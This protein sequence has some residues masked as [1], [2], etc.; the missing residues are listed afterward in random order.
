MAKTA[1]QL[2]TFNKYLNKQP[3]GKGRPSLV[4]SVE[5][6]QLV[7]MLSKYMCTDEEMA[8][9]LGTTVETLHNKNNRETFLDCKK[10]GQA[11]GKV[12]LRRNQMKLSETN[13]T[14]AIWLGKQV[15]GQKDY[16]DPEADRGAVIEWDI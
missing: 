12:S 5:G 13:A 7:E 11:R 9:E 15:L 2:G 1:E 14:M 6:K 8:G 10:R 3:N 16:P 4:L